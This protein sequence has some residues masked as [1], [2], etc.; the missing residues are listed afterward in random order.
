MMFDG[1]ESDRIQLVKPELSLVAE[2]HAAILESEMYLKQFL[3]WVDGALANPEQGMC[4]AM[5]NFENFTN[6]LRFFIVEKSTGKIVGAIGLIIRDK[7]VPFFEIGYWLRQSEQR[8]GFVTEAVHLLEDYAFNEL[9]ARRIEIKMADTNLSSRAVAERCGY[10]LE[11]LV[12]H[13][14]RLPSGELCNSLLF[15]K[16][17]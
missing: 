10:R 17:R 16:I 1:I 7:A 13:D 6:E 12:R 5:A 14:R 8:K 9:S 2:V 15:S 4:D 11:G 3:P